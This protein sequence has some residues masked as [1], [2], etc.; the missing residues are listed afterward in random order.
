[1]SAILYNANSSLVSRYQRKEK[2]RG[3]TD[4]SQSEND[5]FQSRYE[6]D[7]PEY[8]RD[9]CRSV[10]PKQ[11][12]NQIDKLEDA[13]LAAHS[14][15]ALVFQ[16]FVS[17]WFGTKI[18]SSDPE[19]LIELYRVIEL[20]TTHFKNYEFDWEKLI[21]DDLPVVISHHVKTAREVGYDSAKYDTMCKLSKYS[22][23]DRFEISDYISSLLGGE[24]KLQ[25]TFVW[26][27]Y[28][29]LLCGKV[30]HGIAAPSLILEII[31][32]ASQT[33]LAK[34]EL[35]STRREVVNT[36]SWRQKV[37]LLR[38]LISTSK[39]E[40]APGV[41]KPFLH[42]YIF[43]LFKNLTKFEQRRPLLY[44]ICKYGQ[45]LIARQP[46]VDRSLRNA[47][48]NFV[49]GHI[50]TSR[51]LLKLRRLVFPY[52]NTMGPPR[53]ILSEEQMHV[54]RLECGDNL[55]RLL[56]QYKLDKITGLHNKDIQEF[57]AAI[58]TDQKMS[59]LLL[60]RITACFI[61]HAT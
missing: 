26:S 4:P 8:L 34:V 5:K 15:F 32:N 42:H 53:V 51:L 38:S 11:V 16:N 27:L 36:L 22:S 55:W 52:D 59:A 39:N 29:G 3:E 21:L 40:K 45:A 56:Q 24:S 6:K 49:K 9:L 48:H 43:T 35:Q 1:M 46:I 10:Y 18:P 37:D 30:L 19:F 60:E 44:L 23:Y 12:H 25:D 31:N 2:S 14:F 61:A 41:H 28:G 13:S 50:Q 57:V 7:S 33:L 54:L 17:S 20:L 58:S 47:F